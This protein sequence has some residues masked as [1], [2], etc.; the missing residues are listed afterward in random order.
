MKK[1]IVSSFY[2]CLI[3]KEEAI[4]VSTMLAIENVRNKGNLFAVCT[5]NLYKDVLY[6]NKDFPFLDYIIS[7]NGSY[8]YDVKNEKCL[9]K[10]KISKE[11]IE[12]ILSLFNNYEMYLITGTKKILSTAY[13]NEEVYKIEITLP[14]KKTDLT[15]L[16]NLKINKLLI[17]KANKFILEITSGLC[18]NFK[19]TKKITTT[20][21]IDMKDV[22]VIAAN[23]SEI[24]LVKN[25][26]TSFII[27][28]SA[29]ILKDFAKHST[30]SI[31]NVLKK[32]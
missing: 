10:K 11:L 16:N 22:I 1:L 21:N 24:D 20:K 13:N 18:D 29:K 3:N 5:N 12:K 7:L 15:I 17:K 27:K 32:I 2:K 23:E 14:N 4:P 26:S 8:I 30:L 31:E 19:A 6:Y 25:I 28:T 9:Y